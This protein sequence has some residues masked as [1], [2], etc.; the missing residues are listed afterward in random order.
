[1]TGTGNDDYFLNTTHAG[2]I[3]S[4]YTNNNNPNGSNSN[5]DDNNRHYQNKNICNLS[6]KSISI[7]A[8]KNDLNLV[9]PF[10]V[11]PA[12]NTNSTKSLN[13]NIGK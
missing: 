13:S 8:K 9:W 6:D 11:S 10:A 2:N 3:N 5:Y 1:M 4:N 12:A 7:S